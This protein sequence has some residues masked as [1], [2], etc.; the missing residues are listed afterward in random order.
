MI[1]KSF[2]WPC[3]ALP[4]GSFED[5]VFSLEP[6]RVL[7]GDVSHRKFLD[8]TAIASSRHS[9]D[10]F[11]PAASSVRYAKHVR[12]HTA[13]PARASSDRASS[14]PPTGAH[15]PPQCDQWKSRDL[16]MTR[17]SR[18]WPWLRKP[19]SRFPEGGGS[20]GSIGLAWGSS[21]PSRIWLGPNLAGSGLLTW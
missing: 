8:W 17:T 6:F 11:K 21:S 14:R 9:C 10:S 16:G 13:S 3:R 20:H 12:H 19:H 18:G 4:L 7:A 5:G 15:R 2:G 1:L